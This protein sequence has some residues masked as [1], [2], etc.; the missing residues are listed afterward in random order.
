[1]LKPI[2][3]IPDSLPGIGQLDD[4]IV[5]VENVARFMREE[6]MGRRQ[7][8]LASSAEPTSSLIRTSNSSLIR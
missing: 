1:M 5:V 6:G 8:A 2:D 7:A 3:I 4:A